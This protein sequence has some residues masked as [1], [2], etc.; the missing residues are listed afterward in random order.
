[1]IIKKPKICLIIPCYNE[2]EILESTQGILSKK[3]KD[4]KTNGIIDQS[5]IILF[6]DDGSI[7]STWEIIKTLN[8]KNDHLGGVKLSK[9]FGHQNALLAG[10]ESVYQRFDCTITL[11]AD[12]QDDI[13]VMDDMIKAYNEGNHIVYGVRLERKVDNLFKRYTAILFYRI[14]KWLGV[15]IIHN[16]ADYRLASQKVIEHLLNFGEVNLF[17]RG[18]F[19]LIGF[20]QTR[21]YYNRLERSAGYTKYPFFKMLGFAIEGM[22][23]FSVR[24][25]RIIAILGILVFVTSLFLGGYSLYSYFLLKTVPGWT[26]ITLPL[27]FIS[28]I[29]LLGI[30]VLGEYLGK[31]YKETKNRPRFIIEQMLND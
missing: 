10:L 2:Q 23:S 25:L 18:M 29:Q 20:K 19:P 11:D 1:M 15:D 5:S 4:L 14:M 6:V 28:G 7:D 21:V 17:L 26:S 22:T 9:N 16:H 24:P 13:N 31:V 8:T 3:I 30:G 27:Y 12:L